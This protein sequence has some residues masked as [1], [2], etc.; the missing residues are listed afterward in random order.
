MFRATRFGYGVFWIFL[1]I[2][3]SCRRPAM[4]GL[5]IIAAALALA[6]MALQVKAG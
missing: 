5:W 3:E 2:F 4:V 1:F 6:L